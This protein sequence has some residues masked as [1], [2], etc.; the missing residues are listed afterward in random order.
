VS[1]NDYLTPEEVAARLRV[2]RRTV[3]RWITLGKLRALKAG[4]VWRVS[5]AALRDFLRDT[6]ADSAPPVNPE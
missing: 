2:T 1:E 6:T 4:A 5:E 3:Y